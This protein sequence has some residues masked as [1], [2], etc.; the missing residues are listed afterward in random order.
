MQII[1]LLLSMFSAY[2]AYSNAL[3]YKIINTSILSYLPFLKLHHI[4]VLTNNKQIYT[5]DF[6]PKK[7][8]QLSTQLHMLYYY[9]V[10]GE[11]RIRQLKNGVTPSDF[12][13]DEK[14][15]ESWIEETAHS[16]NYPISK[17]KDKKIRTVVQQIVKEWRQDMNLYTHNCQHFS[18]YFINRLI[19]KKA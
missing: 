6:T 2:S 10:P 3:Q 19:D 1:Y 7:Q 11:I 17:I 18:N 15:V 9:D 5:I 14:I 12:T 4:V 8:E 16:V 13:N